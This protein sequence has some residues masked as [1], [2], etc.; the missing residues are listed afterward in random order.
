M[1][2]TPATIPQ[3]KEVH[4]RFLFPFSFQREA[5]KQAVEQLSKASIKARDGSDLAIWKCAE[6]PA[7]Y[8]EELLDHVEG[9]LFRGSER[10]CQYLRLSDVVGNKWFNKLKAVLHEQ[11]QRKSEIGGAPAAAAEGALTENYHVA[12]NALTTAEIFL[13]NY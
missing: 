13:S 6:P 5:A 12:L 3:P 8:R 11:K 2:L 1:M 9:F 10:A 4:T 7:L